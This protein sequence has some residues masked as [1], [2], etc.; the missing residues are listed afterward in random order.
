MMN[1]PT[2]GADAPAVNDETRILN[3]D[4]AERAGSFFKGSDSLK[5]ATG[6]S[7][8]GPRIFPDRPEEAGSL[9]DGGEISPPLHLK[10]F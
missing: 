2:A 6:C 10:K 1:Y 8:A 4:H 3:G 7:T 9:R 5:N